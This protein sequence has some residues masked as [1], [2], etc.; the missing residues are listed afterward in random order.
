MTTHIMTDIET[1]G[2]RPGAVILSAAF[3]RFS[4]EAAMSINFSIP[5]QQA[6]G[7]EIDPN[8]QAWWT[9]L[10][11]QSAPT[12]D[13]TTLHQPVVRMGSRWR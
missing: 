10:N 2:T 8:T 11:G 12:R 9:E 4:D 7:L 3:V 5:E 6:L 13:R 1:L